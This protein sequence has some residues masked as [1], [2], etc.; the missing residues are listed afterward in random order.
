MSFPTHNATHIDAL[1]HVHDGDA[2]YNGHPQSGMRPFSGAERCGVQEIGG[3]AARGACSW[4]W[5][6]SA[7]RRSTRVRS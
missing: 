5:S 6:R 3:F 4:T 1:C 7:G 2:I